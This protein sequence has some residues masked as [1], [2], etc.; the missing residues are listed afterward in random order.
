[1]YT[2]N[3]YNTAER[4]SFY[5]PTRIL[6][7]NNSRFL[8]DEV[9]S[10]RRFILVVDQ[11]FRHSNY[12]LELIDKLNPV[13]T[14]EIINEP[15]ISDFKN[16]IIKFSE[17]AEYIVAIGGGAS[18]DFAKLLSICKRTNNFTTKLNENES[19]PNHAKIIALPTTCGSGSET[20][21]YCVIFDKFQ[22]KYSYRHWDLAPQLAILDP[23][24][25]QESH[26][27]QILS[28]VFDSFLHNLEA[29]FL[30][31]EG[32]D[33]QR[34]FILAIIKDI[35]H[36]IDELQTDGPTEKNIRKLMEASALGGV[37]ISNTRTGLVHTFAES[38][39]SFRKIP[40][41][42]ALFIFF[43][44]ILMLYNDF[45]EEKLDELGLQE[46]FNL[47]DIV[48]KW[49]IMHNVFCFKED[50][51]LL[52]SEINEFTEKI[53]ED[54]VIF[55]EISF[56]LNNSIIRKIIIDSLDNILI[57]QSKNKK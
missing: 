30:K 1:M 5:N 49:G 39:V 56:N 18:I 25:M 7:Y 8:L 48:E 54:N 42:N 53:F 52:D 27:N 6:S 44:E 43:A 13:F 55:K 28:S 31:N 26:V 36:F 2:S 37:S 38:F 33:R 3:I 12:I 47:S 32:D 23:W 57:N 45:F 29:F 19:I 11:F 21:R 17:D 14:V 16:E 51:K 34:P 10:G 41:P 9:L 24:F 35:M 4:Y 22:S 46:N 20:S 15:E 40:H 50:I